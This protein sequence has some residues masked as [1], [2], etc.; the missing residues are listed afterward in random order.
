MR[1]VAAGDSEALVTA[2]GLSL[3]V[4]DEVGHEGAM[5][6]REFAQ[7]VGLS[8][9][10]SGLLGPGFSAKT[11]STASQSEKKQWAAEYLKTMGRG[12]PKRHGEP[13]HALIFPGLQRI[14]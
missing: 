1:V 13:L 3:I 8:I 5:N 10:G 7:G 11:P 4:R 2:C 9:V 14:G 12:V 6:R